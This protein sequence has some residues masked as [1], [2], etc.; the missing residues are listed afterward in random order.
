MKN[1]Q[2]KLET[3]RQHIE[4]CWDVRVCVRKAGAYVGRSVGAGAGS[5]CSCSIKRKLFTF[6]SISSAEYLRKA[7]KGK[8]CKSELNPT[9]N[10]YI[11]MHL[12]KNIIW[13]CRAVCCPQLLGKC[14][15]RLIWLGWNY[16]LPL[17]LHHV[18]ELGT[19]DLQLPLAL[20]LK[21][22]C[23]RLPV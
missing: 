15:V 2:Y 13:A 19:L 20:V 6:S 10:L 23:I 7:N 8:C 21:D 5:S 14:P 4:S 22:L 9:F 1:R 12:L 11:L 17:L 18:L 16:T 3:T